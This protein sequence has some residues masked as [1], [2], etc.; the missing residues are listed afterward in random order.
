MIK[1]KPPRK[2][3]KIYKK[4][5]NKSYALYHI[6]HFVLILKRQGGENTKNK[7]SINGKLMLG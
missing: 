4:L 3:K 1:E 5:Y 7:Q 2:Q 6:W